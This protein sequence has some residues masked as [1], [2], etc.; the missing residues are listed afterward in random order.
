M[1]SVHVYWV[2]LIVKIKCDSLS[3][4]RNA[5]LTHDLFF[6]SPKEI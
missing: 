4:H 6:P 1:Y 3:Q 2:R 5:N